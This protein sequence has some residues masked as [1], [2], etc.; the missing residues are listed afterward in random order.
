MNVM[1]NC[2]C[3]PFCGIISIIST[4]FIYL[5]SSMQESFS[6]MKYL[7]LVSLF[8]SV[9]L[10]LPV[11]LSHLYVKTRLPC[12]ILFGMQT[13]KGSRNSAFWN[14]WMPLN[15]AFKAA[16]FQGNI[17]LL[18]GQYS[19][20][21]LNILAQNGEQGSTSVTAKVDIELAKQTWHANTR[22]GTTFVPYLSLHV[23]QGVSSHIGGFSSYERYFHFC[24]VK[25]LWRSET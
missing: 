19:M 20:C 7:L 12:C 21:F 16:L 9:L 23:S 18:M 4:S 3:I 24:G 13:S 15:L 6:S 10:P 17:S 8:W 5:M 11:N 25:R 1:K 22:A 2:L 14:M